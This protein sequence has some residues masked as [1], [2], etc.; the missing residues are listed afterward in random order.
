MSG[1]V[2]LEGIGNARWKQVDE[3]T[4]EIR[5]PVTLP[6]GI[7]ARDLSVC[8]KDTMILVVG[9]EGM[10]TPIIQWRLYGPVADEVEW[11]MEGEHLVIELKKKFRGANWTALLDLPMRADDALLLSKERLDQL[12]VTHFPSQ[13]EFATLP[14][15]GDATDALLEEAA[16]ELKSDE[17][18]AEEGVSSMKTY[19]RHERENMKSTEESIRAKMKQLEVVEE[20]LPEQEK[21]KNV[22]FI[23]LKLHEQVRDIRSRPSS[24]TNIIETT[25]LSIEI[26][27]ANSG[28]FGEEVE[29]FAN[30][31][32]KQLTPVQLLTLALNG[33]SDDSDEDD[34]RRYHFLRLAAIQ[35]GH[36]QSIAVLFSQM[37]SVPLGAYLLLKRALD[38]ENPSAEANHMVGDLFS[39]GSKFF[40]PLF[41][42]A[43]YFYQRSARL[44]YVAAM[45]SLAQL[46][47]RGGTERSL[48]SPEECEELKNISWYHAWLQ[49]A[50][51]RGSGAALFVQGCMYINGEHGVGRSYE[52]AKTLLEAASNTGAE[53]A[54]LVR[55]SNVMLKLEAMKTEEAAK[56][57]GSGPAAAKETLAAPSHPGTTTVAAAAPS[58]AAVNKTSGAVVPSGA[59]PTSSPLSTHLSP[60]SGVDRVRKA[61]ATAAAARRMRFWKSAGKTAVVGY[62]VFVLCFP[63]R[64]M[65]LP[66][67]YQILGGVVGAIPWLANPDYVG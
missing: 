23:M 8:I 61:G 65:L 58:S 3:E 9:V 7:R 42:A 15:E 34:Q 66:H 38:N 29:E 53:I 26:A 47:S 31:E 2:I 13:P 50:V 4:V 19:L 12:A 67:L 43:V 27:R 6:D 40:V 21:M 14:G 41:P 62:G 20:P 56:T 22:L 37:P 57:A 44:G 33:G 17:E 51:D 36:A 24:V 28:S 25:M 60:N 16:S 64:V 35:H 1:G 54:Q 63:F 11:V 52:R 18:A 49:K 30:E 45:L 39:G 32:E 5:I 10:A 59:K 55:N 48:Q 46:W